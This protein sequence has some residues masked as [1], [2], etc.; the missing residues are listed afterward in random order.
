MP[1]VYQLFIRQV[2]LLKIKSILR[3]LIITIG[4]SSSARAQSVDEY[5]LSTVGQIEENT[6]T[7]VEDLTQQLPSFIDSVENLP[8]LYKK[9]CNKFSRYFWGCDRKTFF[10]V[11]PN[12]LCKINKDF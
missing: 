9:P 4:I 10:S 8:E 11:L 7:K 2:R 5:C 12:L 6:K 3:I 1:L